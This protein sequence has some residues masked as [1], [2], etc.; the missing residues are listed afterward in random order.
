M[1]AHFRVPDLVILREGGVRSVAAAVE[2]LAQ[3]LPAIEAD[4][5]R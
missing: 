1:G 2:D 4:E 3:E 5:E